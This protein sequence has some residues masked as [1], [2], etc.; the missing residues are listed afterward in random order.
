M[1][2]PT[3]F[4]DHWASIFDNTKKIKQIPLCITTK[5]VVV[6]ICHDSQPLLTVIN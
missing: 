6:T 5:T 2:F 3:L 1:L 4:K